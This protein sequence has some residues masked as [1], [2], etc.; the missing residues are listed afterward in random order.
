[1]ADNLTDHGQ[2]VFG[3][4]NGLVRTA[5]LY[6][7][8]HPQTLKAREV[9]HGALTAYLAMNGEL[10][11]RFLGDVLVANDRILARESL[12]YRRLLDVCQKERQIGS[13]TFITGVEAREL[14]VLLEA[15]TQGVG[16]SLSAWT[17][18]RGLVHV[19]LEPP[20]QSEQHSIEVMARRAYYGS[21]DTLREIEST[22]RSHTP[23]GI[24]QIGTLRVFTSALLEQI[25]QIPDLVLRLASIKSYDEYTLY[26]S[27]NV[28]V[29]SMGLGLVLD[30]P[31]ALLHEVAMAGMLHDLGKI[32]VPLE[33]LQKPGPLDDEEWK[34][35]RQHPLL[36][37]EIL[38]RLSVANRLPMVVAFEHHM[39]FDRKGYPFLREN[40]T[41]HPV[42]RLACVADVFDAMTSRRA[43]KNAISSRNVCTYVRD[44]AGQIFDPRLPRILDH[45]VTRLRAAP[46]RGTPP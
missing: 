2:L 28:A 9:L 29:I 45:M 18:Q 24:E 16:E 38:S 15:L 36:G 43:Y 21:V 11:Y 37:A 7:A 3:H 41:Q 12:V 40:W 34:V 6:P 23:L 13:I 27:V 22:I 30:L 19:I 32:A 8:T 1:M 31:G 42:S 26:H 10:T 20:M 25:L 14:D 4:L 35:M 44:Q 17:A 46:A 39:R 33:I 5:A